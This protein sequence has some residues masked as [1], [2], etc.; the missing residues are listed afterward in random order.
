M[1]WKKWRVGLLV[2]TLYSLF[3]AGSTTLAG[4][5]W[6]VFVAAFCTAAVTNWT[7][8]LTKHPVEDV[9]DTDFL[10]KQA[11]RRQNSKEP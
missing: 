6:K 9:Q 2:A 11:A 5:G 8:Y 1:N 10:N 3:V 4:G 7:A